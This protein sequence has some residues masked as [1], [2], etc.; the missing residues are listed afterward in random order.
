MFESAKKKIDALEI[1]KNYSGDNP[2]ILRLKRDAF[3]YNNTSCIND[4][5]VEYV[6]ENKNTVPRP[7]GKTL[8]VADWYGEKLKE[9]YSIEFTP[10]KVRFL[11]Y[12]GQTSAQ[13]E[14]GEKEK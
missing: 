8:K 14:D 13:P 4:F 10:E 1:I 9:T 11:V 7:I 12:I 3:A 2:Y 6:L 5:A